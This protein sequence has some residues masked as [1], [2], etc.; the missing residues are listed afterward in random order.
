M[1]ENVL[2]QLSDI[3]TKGNIEA[4]LSVNVS[5]S[6]EEAREYLLLN[7]Y[8][9]SEEELANDVDAEEEQEVAAEIAALF[10]DGNDVAIFE[11]EIAL[12]SCTDCDRD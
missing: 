7:F 3:I 10:A 2:V 5:C 9:Y 6:K 12:Q 11:H 8:G 4:D 1:K